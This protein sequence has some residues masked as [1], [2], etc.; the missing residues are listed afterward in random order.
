[1]DRRL[2]AENYAS[3]LLADNPRRLAHSRAVA[4]TASELADVLLDDPEERSVLV[5]AAWLHDIGYAPMLAKTGAHH[6]DGAI[7]LEGL[8]EQRLACLVAHH[9]SGAAETALRGFADEFAKFPR[10]MSLV[11]DILTYCDLSCGPDGTRLA[12]NERLREIRARYG[13]DHVVVRG[14][15]ADDDVIRGAFRRVDLRLAN[16]K[17]DATIQAITGSGRDSPK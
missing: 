1:M 5:A 15:E 2:W 7:H 14:L 12:L 6:L 17:P 8:G 16:L 4:T 13:D 10:E 9:G 3:S 11:A